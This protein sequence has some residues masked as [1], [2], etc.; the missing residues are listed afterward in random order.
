[1]QARSDPLDS[2]PCTFHLADLYLP[3]IAD[4]GSSPTPTPQTRTT[5]I[6]LLMRRL[7]LLLLLV[8][9][10]P[11][12]SGRTSTAAAESDRVMLAGMPPRGG[13]KI[14]GAGD[15]QDVKAGDTVKVP[16][17]GCFNAPSG[18]YGSRRDEPVMRPDVLSG[19]GEP[20]PDA[21]VR[22]SGDKAEGQRGK[23]VQDRLDEG[24]TAGPAP[25]GSPVHAVQQL[26][27]RDAAIPTSSS[28]PSCSS[29]RLPAS[30]IAFP[31]GRRRTTRSRS[32]KTV[33]SRSVPTGHPELARRR[34]ARPPCR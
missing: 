2:A 16:E 21:G 18:S 30:A 33:V 26:G 10:S 19:R 8:T 28:D 27:G 1:M 13:S 31:G 20:G 3:G 22:T 11:A 9:D 15:G 7:L 14:A 5:G 6:W 24:L 29:R 12:A 4:T 32:M 25:G 34:R 17:I 23:R